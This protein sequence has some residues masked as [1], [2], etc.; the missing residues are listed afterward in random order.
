MVDIEASVFTELATALRTAY[1]GVTVAGE[2]I[3]APSKFPFVSIVEADNY[4]E[5]RQLST[6]D[7]EQYAHLMYEVNVYSNKAGEKKAECRK[8][9][10]Y[11]DAMLY[12]MN[13]TRISMNPV[14]N[15]EDASIYRL[16]ARY[17]AV[18]DGKTNYR[19]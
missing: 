8:L 6:A 19:K 1:P 3:N 9:L 7:T 4:V 15:M 11:I 16:N 13:F 2:Y 12:Q 14:P 10:K 18:S 5:T 17:E